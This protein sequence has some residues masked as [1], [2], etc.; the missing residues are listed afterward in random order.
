MFAEN[1]WPNELWASFP[2]ACTR[3]RLG[4]ETTR[5]L[6]R[7]PLHSINMSYAAVAASGP[8]QTPEEAAAPPPVE[9]EHSES[10]ST[11]SLIDVD[12]PSVHTVPSDF[13][14]QEVQTSTQQSRIEHEHEEESARAEADLAKKKAAAKVKKADN[15]LTKWFGSLSDG[16][17]SALVISNLVGVIGLSGFLGYKAWDLHERGRLGWKNIGLGVGVLA[18]V[19]AI[20]GVFGGYF[21]K[22]KKKQS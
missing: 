16:E 18:A 19:G 2:I 8:K 11:A 3:C 14:E 22:G 13:S 1:A 4:D 6:V 20:Q 21:Y 9:I 5:T 10:A 17:S 7:P 12:T 15:V